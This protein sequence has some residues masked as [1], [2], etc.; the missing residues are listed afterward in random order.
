MRPVRLDLE[1]F[2]AYRDR[3]EVD[4]SDADLFV[5]SGP[6]GSGKTSVIDAMVFALYGSIPRLDRKHLEPL[7]HAAADRGRVLFEFSVG[8]DQWTI[9][10]SLQRDGAGAKTTEVRLEGPDVVLDKEREVTARVV[11]ILG[12]DFDQFT[13][14]VVL[15]QGAFARFLTDKASDRQDLLRALLDLGLFEEIKVR[16]NQRAIAATARA[17][18]L[19]E[20]LGK[21]EIPDQDEIDSTKARLAVLEAALEEAPKRLEEVSTARSMAKTVSEEVEA[22]VARCSALEKAA[23]AAGVESLLADQQAADSAVGEAQKDLDA[24]ASAIASVTEALGNLPRVEDLERVVEAVAD[25][26]DVESAIASLSIPDLEKAIEEAE[27]EAAESRTA[28]SEVMASHSAHALR[29]DLEPGKECP[30]CR[31]TVDELPESDPEVLT[32]VEDLRQAKENADERVRV[33]REQLAVATGRAD[34]LKSRLEKLTKVIADGPEAAPRLLKEVSELKSRME[35]LQTA[36][37]SLRDELAKAEARRAATAEKST[38][39]RAKFVAGRD[40][41][42]AEGPPI[43]DGTLAL[44]L[45]VFEEWRRGKLETLA[46]DLDA[47]RAELQQR[48]DAVVQAEKQVSGWAD[49]L[50][51]ESTENP[52]RDLGLAVGRIRADLEGIAQTMDQAAEIRSQLEVEKRSATVAHGLGL[53]LR[54]NRFEAWV[55]EEAMHVLVGGAN[56]LLDELSAGAY[57]LSATAGGFEI[58]DHRHADQTRPI[59]S[60]SGGE[61]FLV[62]LSLALSM[63]SQLAEL[64][65]VPSRLESVFLDEG[66]GSLDQESLDVVASVLDELVG[67][68]RTVGIVTHVRELSDRIPVRFEVTK[69]PASAS[70]EKVVA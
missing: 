56:R 62:S 47:K 48:N 24:G 20:T 23:L 38:E 39:A 11:D 69:G 28:L 67:Q 31:R 6:T 22:L 63:A 60:L 58:I 70:V 25:K 8:D 2:M 61:L 35:D 14:A 1:G 42:A 40:A 29:Q 3:I 53:H 21:L 4:F 54:A 32:S 64:A 52:E 33:V 19:E 41:V 57:S 51:L 13:K 65:N 16:A 9:A 27:K 30:V 26:D 15:P 44:D 66:F 34:E 12:L 37:R 59:K 46:R 49:S 50:G 7:I 10:R 18:G 5:L 45:N 43:P 17:E 55:M 36:H 68:G